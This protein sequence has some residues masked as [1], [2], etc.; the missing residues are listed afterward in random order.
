MVEVR[1][2]LA[3][4]F[5]RQLQVSLDETQLKFAAPKRAAAL[6]AY[7]ILHR[8]PVARDKVAFALWP[9][10]TE[11]VARANLRRHVHLLQSALSPVGTAWIRS[12]RRSV[13]W[14][15][16]VEVWVDV[17]EFERLGQVSSTM[18]S[19]LNLY[20]GDLLPELEDEWLIPF[21][22]RFRERQL[23]VL[24]EFAAFKRDR[25]DVKKAISLLREALRLDP[26]REDA[27]RELIELRHLDGDRAGALQAYA[28]F[29][30]RLETELD[31]A[32]TPETVAVYEA[33]L[34]ASERRHLEAARTQ[35]FVPEVPATTLY[36]RETEIADI[37]HLL[38]DRVLITLA[39][40]GGVGK[41]RL[42]LEC[43]SRYE[44]GGDAVRFVDLAAVGDPALVVTRIAIDLGLREQPGIA[45]VDSI[46]AELRARETLVVL[47]N[48]EHVV[49]EVAKVAEALAGACGASRVIATSREPLGV[50]AELVYRV[51]PLA[52]GNVASPAVRLFLD[53]ASDR[54]RIPLSAYSDE[55][56][57]SICRRLDG[58]PLALELA[59]ARARVVDLETLARGLDDRFSLLK[60]PVR[61]APRQRT[62][63]A[64]IDWSYDLLDVQ[65]RELFRRLSV[66]RGPFTLAAAHEVGKGS[67]RATEWETLDILTGLMDKSL[68]VSSATTAGGMRYRLLESM[69]EYGDERLAGDEPEEARRHH[70]RFYLQVARDARATYSSTSDSEWIAA[71]AFERDNFQAALEWSVR[72][73][74]YLDLGASLAASLADFWLLI[75]H[76]SVGLHWLEA[77]TTQ[78]THDDLSAA[79]AWCGLASIYRRAYRFGDA[80]HAARRA[81]S[82]YREMG[83][84]HGL[85]RALI[86][87]GNCL[88]SSAG[89]SSAEAVREGLLLVSEAL[90]I[91][92]EYGDDLRTAEALVTLGFVYD[93]AD[94]A[95]R[96][97]SLFEEALVLF[98]A[99]GK[100]V[101]VKHCLVSIAL[102]SYYLGDRARSEAIVND[103]LSEDDES[104]HL[105]RLSMAVEI[106]G[107]LALDRGALETGAT[108]LERA[109]VLSI[110]AG[111]DPLINAQLINFVWLCLLRG[112]EALGARLLGYLEGCRARGTVYPPPAIRRRYGRF[113]AQLEESLGTEVYARLC[114]EGRV[115][116]PNIAIGAVTS[117]RGGSRLVHANEVH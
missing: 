66:F 107:W 26:W 31:V 10:E 9:D 85:C 86:V 106:A 35:L 114:G 4:R 45:L 65:E 40:P 19:A 116:S 18:E 8:G 64:M 94:E 54:R 71:L 115:M 110:E 17:E 83:N 80:I 103:L 61:A 5:F 100:S 6:L 22:E 73:Q 15:R 42:A 48:C 29:A 24:I 95:V 2:A 11:Q 104:P 62:L 79:D 14:N 109:L 52:F 25:G 30:R 108:H 76:E 49:A 51:E 84:W 92:R 90:S 12:D 36:G 98:E 46:C 88:A 81:I 16:E 59:A 78:L 112:E 56:V 89:S 97:L 105:L 13:E 87:H 21:R 102:M 28:D 43:A 37:Q 7:L 69:R 39:G 3:I 101:R 38:Q 47:D 20:R 113:S 68:I 60:D 58:I 75:G 99:L 57:M 67:T 111:L 41:T 77:V 82:P 53:R 27:I 117:R 33:V 74:H 34:H 96:A 44:F 32:P 1:H 23:S 91:A 55:I 70:A 63:R 72:E 50:G 93:Y